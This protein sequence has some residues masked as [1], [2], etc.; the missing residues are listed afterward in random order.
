MADATLSHARIKAQ[1]MA[2]LELPD[3]QAQQAALQAS[4]L[5]EQERAEVLDLLAASARTTHFAAPIAQAAT[6]WLGHEFQPGEQLGAWRLVRPL[7]EGGMGRVFLAERADGAYQQQ[8]ALKL[9]RLGLSPDAV[10]RFARER[11]ILAGLEHPHIARL[12]DGGQ[13]P[14][15]WPF[16]VMEYVDGEPIDRW[17]ARHALPLDDRLALL[18]TL[19]EAVAH[20]HRQLVIHCDL[21]PGNVLVDRHGRL[22]LLDFGIAH[23]EGQQESGAGGH[24]PGYASPEQAAGQAPTVAGDVYSLGCLLATLLA[25][26]PRP[27]RR[28]RRAELQAIVAR[29]TALRPEDRY[30]DVGS[31]QR[32]L[33]RFRLQQPVHALGRRRLYVAAKLLQRRWPW[34]LA[35]TAALTA[36]GLFTWQLALE[37]D[38][39][40]AAELQA[41]EE[42]RTAREVTDF[43]V[44]LFGDADAY[45]R[46]RASELRALTLLERGHERLRRDLADR[47]RQRAPLLFKLGLV[48]ENVGQ[49]ARAAEL[50]REAIADYQQVGDTKPLPELYNAYVSVLN[51]LGRYREALRAIEAWQRTAAP[52]GERMAHID[53]ALGIVLPNLGQA[54]QARLHLQRALA[55]Q[56]LLPEQ[57]DAQRLNVRSRTYLA[58]LALVALAEQRPAEAE[59]LAR[60][61]L[62]L[63]QGSAFRRH[64][65][66]GLALMDQGRTDEALAQMRLGDAAAVRHFGE[67]TGNR[68]RVLRDYGWVLLRAGRTAEAIRQLRLALQCAEES[69]EAGHPLAAQTQL[70]LAQ[71]LAASGDRA[72]ARAAFDTAL[73]W[74]QAHEADGDPLGL[75]RIRTERDAFL[76]GG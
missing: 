39:A 43:L 57:P 22:R 46:A 8:A 51:R 30:G 69:G 19:C 37:R 48:L 63:T 5:S 11:Q 14:E 53:N 6:Q 7:G 60:L 26:L 62:D 66:L 71:A 56:G 44:N 49:T 2:A 32:D 72:G 3:R 29:A 4:D 59:R 40:R 75:A 58:N 23:I 36:A 15:G 52:V 73:R 67:L 13:T 45:A 24:T 27:L 76:R 38:R 20:A 18:Q 55:Q 70:R 68:H 34:W 74:A 65:I 31:L 54:A 9:V 42:A 17:C 35:A 12:L 1:F 16:L 21:K 47:P 64:A 10:A 28:G 61:A 41:Q 33:Q 50:H 25:D